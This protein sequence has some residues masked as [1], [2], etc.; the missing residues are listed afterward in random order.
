MQRKYSLFVPLTLSL[1][2][3]LLQAQTDMPKQ[4]LKTNGQLIYQKQKNADS[5]RELFSEGN[6]Y[7]RLRSNTFYFAYDNDD[8]THD[9]QLISGLGASLV[10]KSAKY[11]GFDT[12]VGLYG[13]RAFFNASNDPAAYIKAGKD[14][15]SRF[16]YANTGSK[17]M[18]VIGQA[19]IGYTYSKT[20]LIV[21]RQLVETFYTKSNDTKMIPNTFD[22]LVVDSKNI[23]NTY[24]KFAYLTKQKLRDHT[25]A[26]AVLMV[27]DANSTSSLKPQWSENDDGAMHKG[28]TYTALKAAGKPTDAPLIVLDAQNNSINN[29]KINFSAYLVPEL[30][31]QV[32]T[33]LNYKIPLKGFSITP[34]LRYIEQFDNGAGAVGG[35]S[36]YQTGLSGYKNANS[37]DS[38]MIAVRLVTKIKEYKINLG[39]TQILD[40]ADLVTPWRGF[41]TA[42]YTRSM[43]MYNWRANVKSYRLELVYGANAKGIYTKPFIQTSVLYIDGDKNKNETDSMFYYA[44]I[45]QNIPSVKEL[46][47]RVRL[48]W[49]DFI[50][51]SSG[52]S[53]YLDA[54]LEFN[55]LF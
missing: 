47:Y 26:H 49:R 35:A 39:Y 54:R 17:S 36:I 28:L 41:P 2:A 8:A 7:G 31:S 23:A 40:K 12:I 52:V 43:G 37:L 50:G 42:G 55:Y 3:S 11:N 27:G 10:F 30:L 22:G 9:T 18:G 21:G 14:T 38:S 16:D 45:V 51:D 53:D 4:S 1:A 48:G 46:Q 44:G 6:F 13:S 15:F 20:K 19:N 24:L 25:D 33:E 32:M 34:G 5:L 29:L